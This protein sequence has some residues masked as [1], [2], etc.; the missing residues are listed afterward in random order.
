MARA[1]AEIEPAAAEIAQ[2]LFARTN[3]EQIHA[4]DALLRARVEALGRTPLREEVVRELRWL[5]H[6]QACCRRAFNELAV[7]AYD[8]RHPK[9]WLWRSHKR[10]ILD[11]VEPGQRVLDVGSGASAYL[12]WMAEKG[13]VVT[14]CDIRPDRVELARSLMQHPNLRFELRDAVADPPRGQYDWLICS[15][16]IEHIDDPVAFLKGLS[17]CAPRL[18][19]CVPPLDNAWE[20]VMLRDLGLP[21]MDDADHRREYTPELLEEQLTAAGWRVEDLRAGV[22]IKATAVRA[23]AEQR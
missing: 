17:P 14:G 11:R 23:E 5:L 20:K 19:V 10:Y 13:C 16:V 22:D 18:I 15:H 9:H 6:I 4:L 8:G 3:S 12:L 2:E 7:L 1:A 21:W